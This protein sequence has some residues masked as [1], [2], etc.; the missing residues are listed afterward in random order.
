MWDN[1]EA[2]QDKSRSVGDRPQVHFVQAQ[3][4]GTMR[5]VVWGS[6]IDDQLVQL[7]EVPYVHRLVEA[8]AGTTSRA[9]L[10]EQR[11]VVETA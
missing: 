5:N 9:G 1:I 11:Q 7:A 4:A 2:V 8:L 10:V 3:A 6:H